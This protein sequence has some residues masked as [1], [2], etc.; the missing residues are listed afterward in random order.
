MPESVFTAAINALHAL[1]A[2]IW[3]GGMF[4]AYV[5]LRPSLGDHAPAQRL[6][7]WTRVF[8]RF[9]PW[10]WLAVIVLPAT[11]YAAIFVDFGGFASAGLHVHIMQG[12]G[13]VMIALFVYLFAVPF[14]HL[15]KAVAAEDW[16][17]AG[18]GLAVIRRIVGANLH[19]GLINVAIGASGRFWP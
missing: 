5:V 3:V 17:D 13:L 9:F 11:G 2:V 1:S 8:Q 4:F 19:L 12:I 15:K 16:P 7:L 18:K 14:Q 10:V 6:I